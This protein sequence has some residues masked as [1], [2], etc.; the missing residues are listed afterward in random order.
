M[1]KRV[2]RRGNERK[3]DGEYLDVPSLENAYTETFQ[4]LATYISL[5]DD[6]ADDAAD[7]AVQAREAAAN[8][9]VTQS[10]ATLIS[11]E[12]IYAPGVLVR[13]GTVAYVKD[14]GTSIPDL[15][16]WSPAGD[17]TPAHYDAV[18]APLGTARADTPDET[19]K[20]KAASDWAAANY[21]DMLWGGSRQYGFTNLASGGRH[22]HWRSTGRTKLI[23]LAGRNPGVSAIRLTGESVGSSAFD[24]NSVALQGSNRIKLADMSLVKAGHLIRILGSRLLPGDNRNELFNV[25]YQVAIVTAVRD[26]FVEISDPLRWTFQQKSALYTGVAQAGSGSS[27]TLAAGSAMAAKDIVRLPIR[28][29]SGTGAG[30]RRFI[31]AYDPATKIATIGS[32]GDGGSPFSPAPDATSAYEIFDETSVNIYNPTNI[33]VDGFD[34]EGYAENNVVARG[35]EFT[36]AR[37]PVVQDCQIDGFSQFGF[38]DYNNY[39]PV[40]RDCVS[41]NANWGDLDGGGQG[42]G[43]LHVG[44]Y[45]P[46]NH[47]PQTSGCRTGVDASAGCIGL[48]VM[49]GCL[50]GGGR[51]WNGDFFWP[52]RNGGAEGIPNTGM[53]THTGA[54]DTKLIGVTLRDCSMWGKV[55]GIG[56]TYIDCFYEGATRQGVYV[57]YSDGVTIQGGRQS[58]DGI[59]VPRSIA[60]VAYKGDDSEMLP[61]ADYASLRPARLV[62]VSVNDMQDINTITVMGVDATGLKE[63]LVG[64]RN[65][66]TTQRTKCP[67]V[68]IR[69]N[70]VVIVAADSANYGLIRSLDGSMALT[71]LEVINN[72]LIVDGTSL[73]SITS[74][75]RYAITILAALTNEALVI[76]L[77][78]GKYIVCLA[79]N[80]SVTI[81]I[82]QG[83]SVLEMFV[84]ECF[85][86]QYGGSTPIYK[87]IV[88]LGS[89]VALY[90]AF[91]NATLVAL[92]VSNLAGTTGA[93]GKLNVSLRSADNRVIL[94]NQLGAAGKFF[95]S[96]TGGPE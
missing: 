44:S 30:Q 55:R 39:K 92:S 43:F 90:T 21:R 94:E 27:I 73:G 18:G 41:L 52:N 61:P 24:S 80:R 31:T 81:P 11:S 10:R 72:S 9:A 48:T 23:Q 46:T 93:A 78:G 38:R 95:I 89:N 88:Q 1:A 68:T 53:S 54:V 19:A 83:C 62:E 15:P 42:Y 66:Y 47:N 60:G 86:T 37:E 16:G 76:P 26:G 6:A 14:G 56:D 34:I 28:I 77:G 79:N 67:F 13:A 32:G 17:V 74:D 85:A 87:G 29:V 96:V 69:D 65:G 5:A 51:S 12:A 22:H 4:A 58:F 45:R 25:T 7:Y 59:Y 2:T 64:L 35:F 20:L 91:N 49:G 3:L 84:A 70:R 8:A 71:G 82:G 36:Y 33:L 40:F 75:N 57:F 50:A 63:Q